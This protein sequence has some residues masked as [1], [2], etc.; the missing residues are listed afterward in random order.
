MSTYRLTV[1][2]DQD[3]PSPAEWGQALT[4]HAD[5]QWGRGVGVPTDAETLDCG[6]C[7]VD[8]YT[9]QDA[10]QTPDDWAYLMGDEDA[11]PHPWTKRADVVTFVLID[12]R[13]PYTIM[14]EKGDTPPEDEAGRSAWIGA[15]VWN[16]DVHPDWWRF[17]ESYTADVV[18]TTIEEWDTYLSGRVVVLDVHERHE[19]DQ[20]F[21]HWHFIDT[22]GGVYAYDYGQDW[23]ALADETL[24]VF[25]DADEVLVSAPW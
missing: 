24:G 17:D 4:L 19:C 13:G 7:G 6:Q 20:G 11:E 9:H 15:L 21:T 23:R 22:V 5:P 16:P 1:E 12:S 2:Y 25:A 10:E 18:R 8:W 3:A 14:R